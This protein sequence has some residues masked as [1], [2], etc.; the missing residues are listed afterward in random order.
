MLRRRDR[1][2]TPSVGPAHCQNIGRLC[3]WNSQ[4]TA[5]KKVVP[6]AKAG[7]RLASPVPMRK[8]VVLVTMIVTGGVATPDTSGHFFVPDPSR[9]CR[10]VVLQDGRVVLLCAN[11]RSGRKGAA[12][13][14]DPRTASW[15]AVLDCPREAGYDHVS[16]QLNSGELLLIGGYLAMA[17]DCNA[18][19]ALFDPRRRQWQSAPAPGQVRWLHSAIVLRDGRVLAWGGTARAATTCEIYDPRLRAWQPAAPLG[20]A[21]RQAA[22]T[23][24]ND[25]RVLTTG[26]EMKSESAT[27]TAEAFEPGTGLWRPLASMLRARYAHAQVLLN[28]GRVL[29]VGGEGA[30]R[31]AEIYDPRRDC[32]EKTPTLAVA[33]SRLGL[34]RL[35]DGRVIAVGGD[36]TRV[37]EIFDPR[38]IHWS[39][40]TDIPSG[41][42]QPIMAA[43]DDGRVLVAG[44]GTSTVEIYDPIA[45]RWSTGPELED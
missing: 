24:L 19:A 9:G 14:Y 35:H 3:A 18:G 11:T 37:V 12:E 31:S 13:I 41:R 8:T 29:V 27:A 7:K 32:W 17:G 15:S 4:P 33:R 16:V 6:R 34:V 40:A 2:H 20:V 10:A 26:G 42:Y 1:E 22:G 30:E 45:D 36:G 43:L 39:R 21:R 25:G 28:D 5:V 23:R 38:R 44:G